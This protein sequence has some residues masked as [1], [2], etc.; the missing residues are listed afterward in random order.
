MY[1]YLFCIDKQGMR[2]VDFLFSPAPGNLHQV[3]VAERVV[4]NKHIFD[5]EQK[6]L[7][8]QPPEI[9]KPP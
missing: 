4:W 3:C 8:L 9:L 6:T 1:S 5:S 2:R 7:S